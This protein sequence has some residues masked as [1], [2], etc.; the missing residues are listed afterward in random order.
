MTTNDGRQMTTK[1]GMRVTIRGGRPVTP[2]GHTKDYRGLI[3]RTY[4]HL[5]ATEL[6]TRA[7]PLD[8]S[9]LVRIVLSNTRQR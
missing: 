2:L 9:S 1:E 6:Q 4:T 5:P 8:T 3:Q 7:R